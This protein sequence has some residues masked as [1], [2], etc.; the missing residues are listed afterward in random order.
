MSRRAPA[1]V[2][3]L[4]VLLGGCGGSGPDAPALG[5][6]TEVCTAG[7]CVSVPDGWEVVEQTDEFVSLAHPA[8]PSI[9]ATVSGVSL[10]ALVTGNGLAWPQTPDVALRSFWALIDDGDAELQTT[11]PLVDGSVTSSGTYSDGRMWFRLIPTEGSRGIAVE[12][13]A[14]NSTWAEHAEA[15]TSSAAEG[16][17]SGG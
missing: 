2:V 6:A 7:F 12:V 15:I 4:A 10:E 17:G 9:G 14:P 16:A 3:A 8:D 11:K 5:A 1:V 13:R